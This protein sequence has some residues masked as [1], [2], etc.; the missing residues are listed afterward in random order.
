MRFFP[1]AISLDISESSI[2]LAYLQKESSGFFDLVAFGREY[3]KEG[4][5]KDGE[6]KNAEGFLSALDS[7]ISKSKSGFPKTKYLIVSLPEERA[8]LRILELPGSLKKEELEQAL[9]YE[10]E[11]NI[12]MSLDEVYFDYEALPQPRSGTHNNIMVNA[13]PKR[14][15]DSYI[16]VLGRHNFSILALEI[17]SV[18]ARRAVFE[19]VGNAKEAVLVLDIGA[20][21]SHF[22]IV[23]EGVLRFTSSNSTAGN[24]LSRLLTEKFPLNIKEAEF[25]KRVVGL[26]KNQQKGKELLEIL[27]PGLDQLKEQIQNYINFFETHP[28]SHKLHDSAQKIS[29]IMLIGGGATL[30]GLVDWLSQELSLPVI[31]G[32]PLKRIKIFPSNKSKLSLE[33]SLG[34]TTALGLAMRSL[35]EI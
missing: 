1:P 35:E 29:K 17:E 25:M 14:I 12:P 9:K 28:D 5:M 21:R 4:I 7:I 3:L 33:E 30:W 31:L 10:L 18:A 20:D 32:N 23:A 19:D 8:F 34:Y 11:A 26:D 16:S 6:I 27:R 22:M 13:I 2:K 15:A 24:K